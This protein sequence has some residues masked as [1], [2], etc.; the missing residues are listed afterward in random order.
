MNV[1]LGPAPFKVMAFVIV[2]P[3]V[4]VESPGG[5]WTVS[6]SFADAITAAT[7]VWF[8]LAAVIVLA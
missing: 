6:P 2:N 5:I 7:S 1:L 8:T 4:Q 3:E